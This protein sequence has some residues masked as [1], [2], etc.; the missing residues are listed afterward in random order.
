M[1]QEGTAGSGAGHQAGT[2][3]KV[4]PGAG[5]RCPSFTLGF[6]MQNSTSCT[7]RERKTQDDC[8]EKEGRLSRALIINS[9]AS[10]GDK[11]PF[12]ATSN[13]ITDRAWRW[14][15]L[16]MRVGFVTSSAQQAGNCK[17][18]RAL[19]YVRSLL[20]GRFGDTESPR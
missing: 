9:L 11:Q 20:E 16:M 17:E 10:Q 8:M 15:Y 14:R 7:C 6:P 12:Q 4:P 13:T 3:K 1:S 19:N 2:A 18:G 5:I